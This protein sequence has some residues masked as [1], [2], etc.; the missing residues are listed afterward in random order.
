MWI[1]MG[2]LAIGMKAN[3]MQASIEFFDLL[4]NYIETTDHQQ[5]RAQ[6]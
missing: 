1:S 4:L 3:E 2:Y 6:S 5:H